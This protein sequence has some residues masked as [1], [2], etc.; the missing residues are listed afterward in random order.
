MI[1]LCAEFG[2]SIDCTSAVCLEV[3]LLVLNAFAQTKV[4]NF[5]ILFAVKENVVG[6]EIAMDDIL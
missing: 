3:L 6:L 2:C 5:D 1:Y 4:T